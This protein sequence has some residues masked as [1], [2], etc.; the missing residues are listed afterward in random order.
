MDRNL[1]MG[2]GRRDAYSLIFFNHEPSTSI[3][4]DFASSPDELLTAAL[5][6]GA[7]GGTDF[8]GALARAHNIMASH[9]S[10][11]RCRFF[12]NRV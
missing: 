7:E 10:T 11:E 4:N 2:G 9:W 12:P 8:T 6:F 3:E 5:R 1:P